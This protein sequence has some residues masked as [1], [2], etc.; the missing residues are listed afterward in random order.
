[1][2]EWRTTTADGETITRACAWSPPGCHPVGC[3]L[4]VHVKDGKLIKVEGDPEHPI[5]RGALCPRC[6]S[7][8]DYVYNPARII[9]PM[10][11]DKKDRGKDKWERCSWEEALDIIEENAKEITKKY[12]AES[13]CVFGGTGREANNY[14][15]MWAN[16]VFGSPNSVYAQSGWSCYGPRCSTTAFMLGGGYPEIDYAQKFYDRY[17]HPG[18]VAPEVILIWGKEPLKSNPDGLWGHAIIDMVKDFGTKLIC[19]D[20]RITWLGT[21][22]EEVLQLRP[23]TDTALAMAF[24]NILISEDLYDHD[25]VDRWTYGFDQLAERVTEMPPEKA[26]EICDVPVDQIYRA[27]RLYGN[28]SPSSV[29][30]GLA[31]DQNPNGVQLGQCLI[32]LM[33]ITGY[34][35]APG[36]TT[37]G[38]AFSTPGYHKTDS[39]VGT[40]QASQTETEETKKNKSTQMNSAFDIA[41][42]NGIMPRELWDK[43]IGAD[44]HPAVTSVIWTVDPDDFL[45]TLESGDPYQIHMAMFSSSNPVGAAISAEPQRWCEALKKLDFNFA[46]DLFMNPTIMSCCDVFLPLSSTIEH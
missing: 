2:T 25:F 15:G 30:W 39:E 19:V 3:G 42:D 32:A 1:M 23:G 4:K 16:A 35:D 18:W 11:R 13:I 34:L 7:L 6:L 27:A 9:Y 5:T 38:R 41:V 22:A 21:R 17:D 29:C 33:S 10:K 8:K 37:L 12:G 14:Y 43:R 36:G 31:V 40:A 20:P 26:A 45:E 46:T 28:A 44:I 24:L